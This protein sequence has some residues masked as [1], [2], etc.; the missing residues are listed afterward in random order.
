MDFSPTTKIDSLNMEVESLI[1]K[2]KESMYDTNFLDSSKKLK[3]LYLK[4]SNI[5]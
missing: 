4:Q 5:H 3:E 1:D 2:K